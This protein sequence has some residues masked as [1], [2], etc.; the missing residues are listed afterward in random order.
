MDPGFLRSRPTSRVHRRRSPPRLVALHPFDKKRNRV[1]RPGHAAEIFSGAFGAA[2]CHFDGLVVRHHRLAY[3]DV[4][5]IQVVRDVTFPAGPCLEGLELELRLAHVAVE[6][7]E[8][9]EGLCS[10]SGVG[11]GRVE[12]LVVFDEDEDVVFL[13]LVEEGLVIG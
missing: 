11:V 1:L 12:A 4:V 6:V 9:A 10:G 7:V 3:V 13:G 5:R 8:V 2:G